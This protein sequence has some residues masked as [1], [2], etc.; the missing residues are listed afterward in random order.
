MCTVDMAAVGL[1]TDRED[2]ATRSLQRLQLSRRSKLEMPSLV[3]SMWSPVGSATPRDVA[4]DHVAGNPRSERST[5]DRIF[6]GLR[7]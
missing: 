2:P 7:A 4:D 5:I 6:I 3:Q 1:G